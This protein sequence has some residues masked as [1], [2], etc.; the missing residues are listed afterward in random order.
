LSNLN[1]TG[2]SG[3]DFN[4]S[5]N[6]AVHASTLTVANV[7]SGVHAERKVYLKFLHTLRFCLTLDNKK[8]ILRKNTHTYFLYIQTLGSDILES[9]KKPFYA[10]Y[11][12]ALILSFD[13]YESE[14]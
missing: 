5:T 2:S 10:R 8:G 7:V 12:F 13:I 11:S 3:T 4:K 1:D 14:R 6:I 9:K